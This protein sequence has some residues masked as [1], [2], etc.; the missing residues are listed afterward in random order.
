VT[1]PVVDVR[2][3]SKRFVWWNRPRQLGNVWQRR[4]R[5][6]LWALRE[7]D[8]QIAA[9]ESV[10][11]IGSNGSGKSTLLRLLAGLARPTEGSVAVHGSVHGLLTLGDSLNTLLTGEENAVS[12]LMLS[13]LT[14]RAADR[15]LP[16][17]AD[18][19]EL[20]DQLDQ[21]LRT[22]SQGMRLRLAFATAT[23]IEPAVLLI[24]E[25]LAVGDGHFQEKCLRRI[26]AL[27]ERGT[28]VV[29]TSHSADQITRLCRRALW[30]SDGVVRAVGDADRVA[31][32]YQGVLREADLDV[33]EAG[34]AHDGVARFGDIVLTHD[35]GGRAT[36]VAPGAGL[37]VTLDYELSQALAGAIVEV[38]I[39]PEGSGKALVSVNTDSDRTSVPLRAGQHEIAVEFERLDLNGGRYQVHVGLFSTDWKTTYAYRWEAATF[40]VRGERG[41]GPLDPPRR[42][43]AE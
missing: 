31:D 8:L 40:D 23:A 13:G 9:G 11:V 7:V 12:D 19:A 36:A 24:D 37:R 4:D 39:H 41:D 20:E 15:L 16:A 34:D 38:A 3:A 33:P 6:E 21:P 18:F 43:K 30:L 42:W 2:R 27:N 35:R 5:T 1:G 14:R 17:V 28:T 26:E 10:G 25:L 29:V 22:Y 32:Q